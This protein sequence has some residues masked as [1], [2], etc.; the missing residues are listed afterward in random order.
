MQESEDDGASEVTTGADR[1]EPENPDEEP[2]ENGQT[3][4][5]DQEGNTWQCDICQTWCNIGSH[6]RHSKECLTQLKNH[7]Q[8]QFKGLEGDEV[9]ITKF[10]LI[11]GDCPSSSCPTGRHYQIP[12][13]CVEWWKREGWRRMGWK[14][15]RE[16]ADANTIK[17]RIRTFARKKRNQETQS[18]PGT[19]VSQSASDIVNSFLDETGKLCSSCGYEGDLVQHLIA[20][21]QCRLA[22]VRNHLTEEEVDARKSMF[23]LCIVLNLCAKVGCA[24]QASFTYLGPHLKRSNKCL[25]F[26]QSEGVYL[27]LPNWNMDSSPGLISKKVA[28]M[29]RT[30]NA[31]KKKEQGFGCLT[32][33]KELSQLLAHTCCKCGTMGPVIGEDNFVMRG[34]W[35]DDATDRA[36]W[37]CSKCSEDS[38]DYNEFRQRLEGEVD[39]LKGPRGSQDSDIKVVRCSASGRSIVAPVCLTEDRPEVS[40]FVPSLST[41]VLV[42][43]DASA[44]RAIMGWCDEALKD[45][46][47]LQEC[48]QELLRRPF[49]TSLHAN[50]SCLY[51]SLLANVR[52]KMGRIMM[53]L[54]K[55][56]RG[57]VLSKNPNTTSARKQAPNLE[58]TIGGALQNM[59]GW[60]YPNEQQSDMEREARSNV[61][62]QVKLHIRGTILKEYEDEELN[63]ILLEGCQ[64]FVNHNITTTEELLADPCIEVFIIQMAPVIL[65][66]IKNKVK[67]FIVHIVAPNFS[68]YDLRLDIDDHKLQV[69]IHGYVYAKQFGEVNRMLAAEPQTKLL[70]DVASI[71]ASEEDVLPTATMNWRNLSAIYNIGELRAKDIVD[72]ARRCQI[73][74]VVFPLSILNLWTPSGWTTSEEEMVLRNRAEELSHEKNIGED[75]KEAIVEIAQTLHQEG[76]FEELVSEDIGGE[77]LQS[78]KRRLIELCPDQPPISVNALMW[79]HVL[80]LR[81]GGG[82][83]WTLKREPGETLVKP[84][85]PL[86]LEALQQHIEV[87]VAMET[88]HLEPERNLDEDRPHERIMAGFAWKEISILKFLQGISKDRYDEPISQATV[89]VITSQEDEI[90][91]NESSEKDE[92][93]DEIYIN[94]KNES[95]VI[96]NGD[97]RKLYTLRPDPVDGMLFGQFIIDFYRKQSHQ[98]ATIDPVSGVGDDSEEPIVGGELRVPLSMKL[99]NAVIM[100]KRSEKPRP[101]PLLL[102]S[103]TLNSYGERMLFQ[104]WRNVEELHQRQSE[105]DKERQKQNRLQLFPMAIFP[106]DDKELGGGAEGRHSQNERQA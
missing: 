46:H 12:K 86:L 94:S 95:Y 50:L 10:T 23:Q 13:V 15:D 96:S 79:Y 65:T 68:N 54:S 62:G 69:E 105:E 43:Y 102:R 39:R 78:I 33:K 84:Y 27:A 29:K 76:L 80:L 98:Q 6:L 83:Q 74:D 14:G 25:E 7:P 60:S 52:H 22:Y 99:T 4:S 40:Q 48:V 18:E 38:P 93:C 28:Q 1:K 64:S 3:G 97:L 9:F 17:E 55:V 35:K 47:E 58:Q 106:R 92:E 85:H 8:F 67:L 37:F 103:N 70:P 75:V 16:N 49:V 19:Q 26:Y 5:K 59:C 41:L 71:V 73:G 32:F 34:G 42:P 90:N 36:S 88:E 77:V 91:F 51:R 31:S 72:V 21:C 11:K 89:A 56:A 87:R 57:E 53:G 20:S 82:N 63:R 101:V 81:T 2:T 104:P 30:I 66:Y 45:K 44:I 24:E 100:K 61:N